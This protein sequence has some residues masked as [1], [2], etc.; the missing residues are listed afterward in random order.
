METRTAFEKTAGPAAIVT[1][2]CVLASSFSLIIVGIVLRIRLVD[3][4]LAS[5]FLI[6]GRLAATLV[7]VAI[8]A[9]LR[10]TDAGFALWALI[11]GLIGPIGATASGGYDLAASVT[12]GQTSNPA[13]AGPILV[14]S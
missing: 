5:I 8:Y 10:E 7:W 3:L 12:N 2:L 9:R 11:I 13:S 4:Q 14:S 1:G 6:I